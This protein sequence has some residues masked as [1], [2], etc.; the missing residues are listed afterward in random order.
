MDLTISGFRGTCASKDIGSCIGW[1]MQNPQDIMV[2]DLS[3]H[4]FSLMRPAPNPPGKEQMLLVEVA[5]G[6]KS[7]S[8][9][10]KAVK[11]L[12]NGGLHLQVRVKN[13]GIAFGVTQP[14][15]QDQFEGSTSCIVS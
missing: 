12:A 6:R 11:D 5:N 14:H 1:M 2:F 15:R 9:V 8:S 7:R 10:L 3:P 4:N 13:N